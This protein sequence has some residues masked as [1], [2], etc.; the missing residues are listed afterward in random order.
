MAATV[1]GPNTG[2]SIYLTP[3]AR[4]SSSFT[5]A[6][7]NAADGTY[8]SAG[9]SANAAVCDGYLKNFGFSIPANAIITKVTLT[10]K[11][12]STYSNGTGI[13]VNCYDLC[14]LVIDFAG[15]TTNTQ[16]TTSTTS[17]LPSVATLNSS[18]W[19]VLVEAYSNTNI[20]GG[21][22]DY[23]AVTVEYYLPP[24]V[25]TTAVTGYSEVGASAS[26]GGNATADGGSPITHKGVCWNT[27]GSPS[28]SDSHTDDGTGTGSYV[29]SLTSL[30]TST[31]YHVR[32]YATSI[33]GTSY[34]TEVT[35]DTAAYLSGALGRLT[36]WPRALTSAEALTDAGAGN[37]VYN[38][39]R[40]KGTVVVQ[41]TVMSRKGSPVPAEHIKAAWWVQNLERGSGTPLY[42]TGHSV[43][44]AAGKNALTIGEDWMEQQ[45]GVSMAQLLAIP[46]PASVDVSPVDMASGNS[47]V[48]DDNGTTPSA[49]AHWAFRGGGKPTGRAG[50]PAGYQW[51][52]AGE[53]SPD[54]INWSSQGEVL[55][56]IGEPW[57]R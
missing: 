30:A 12:F 2:Q 20:G 54:G 25:T 14:P 52:D 22:M 47:G 9:V 10:A 38:R 31:K 32:A 8:A 51:V 45:I 43:D 4:W 53:G 39:S 33:Y 27:A 46:A 44:V 50:A 37:T 24:T 7:L 57:K 42:V 6:N 3:D 16:L 13:R 55:R 40:A 11:G 41:G 36:F 29:S 48:T 23:V 1:V 21:S 18:T 49:G 15:V 34:G 17:S 19:R 26:G 35:F 5:V 28:T 56:P